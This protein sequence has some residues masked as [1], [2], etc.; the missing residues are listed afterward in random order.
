MKILLRV[1]SKQQCQ[2]TPLT[3]SVNTRSANLVVTVKQMAL[4][5]HKTETT[6]SKLQRGGTPSLTCGKPISPWTYT[7]SWTFKILTEFF[8][9]KISFKVTL[10]LKTFAFCSK[11]LYGKTFSSF[12]CF[13]RFCFSTPKR[14]QQKSGGTKSWTLH[15]DNFLPVPPRCWS[16]LTVKMPF[17][18]TF[19][20]KWIIPFVSALLLTPKNSKQCWGCGL[21]IYVCCLNLDPHV[22]YKRFH[23]HLVLASNGMIAT[24]RCFKSQAFRNSFKRITSAVAEMHPRRINR[25]N[26]T[27]IQ[28]NKCQTKKWPTYRMML[29]SLLTGFLWAMF[30]TT[31]HA[32]YQW[33]NKPLK[34]E[35]SCG[36]LLE[37]VG[38]TSTDKQKKR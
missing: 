11:T 30:S 17:T 2:P 27:A 5:L 13:S 33:Q 18:K 36:S 38:V 20:M 34:K 15:P 10:Q 9:I 12:S 23:P 7:S 16:P 1:S 21:A 35:A 25:T 26:G 8:A 37:R 32:V 22:K 29:F 31:L 28:T 14:T 3:R 24:T 4:R 6:G 19:G